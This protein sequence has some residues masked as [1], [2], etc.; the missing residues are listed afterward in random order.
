MAQNKTSTRY[1][2]KLMCAML[3]AACLISLMGLVASATTAPDDPSNIPADSTGATDSDGTAADGTAADGTATDGAASADDLAAEL[4]PALT[5]DK[6]AAL[7]ELIKAHVV[8]DKKAEDKRTARDKITAAYLAAKGEDGSVDLSKIDVEAAREAIKEANEA[9]KSKARVDVDYSSINAADVENLVSR[10][11]SLVSLDAPTGL[12]EK[13]KLAAGSVLSWFTKLV[14]GNY[15]IGLLIFAVILELVT[16]PVSIKQQKNSIKQASLSPKEKAIRKKYAGRDDQATKQKMATEIQEMYQKEGYNPASGC[17]PMILQLVFVL[18]LYAVVVD[19]IVYVMHQSSELSQALVTFINTS[20]ASGGLGGNIVASR[21]TIEVASFITDYGREAFCAKLQDFIYFS[22][23]A[24]IVNA[25]KTNITELNFNLFGISLGPVPSF[26]NFNW[27]LLIPVLTFVVYF[28]SMKITRKMTYQPQVQDQATG[29]SNNIMDITMPL[30]SVY[31]CFV[32]PAALGV[33][34]MFKSILSTVARIILTKVM[35]V[36]T[37]TEEEYK[38]AE[39]E[40]L[41]GKSPERAPAP[42]TGSS[43]K[44][45]R[46]LHHIDDEDFEDT[47]E[48]ALARKARQEAREAEQAQKKADE[49]KRLAD[50]KLIKNEDDRPQLS[51]KQ[52]RE[53]AKKAKQ[54]QAAEKKAAANA[55]E[56]S[57][58][59]QKDVDTVITPE[60]KR[61]VNENKESDN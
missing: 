21:G 46:S 41:K 61:N 39:K 42:R 3:I 9:A 54:Q 19:P 32:V 50:S 2:L 8:T 25:V 22:N 16:L 1:A 10:M 56:A 33:Y 38:A 43:G 27:L 30:F 53:K 15:V 60:G 51:L 34:W 12:F 28:G 11:K 45:V 31:I 23:G 57:A 7:A 18:L 35:P 14:G 58:E 5:E 6:L 26:Q 4:K 48:E 49:E 37:F 59:Q 29:C 17:L 24:D 52:L 13:I 36:P 55:T 20:E 47:R 44:A 40:I